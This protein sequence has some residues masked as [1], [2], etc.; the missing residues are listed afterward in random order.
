MVVS[1]IEYQL[2]SVDADWC[3]ERWEQLPDDGNRYEVIDG[4]LYMSTAPSNNHQYIT[5]RLTAHIG[6]PLE[7]AGVA[8]FAHAP[9]GVIMPG[10]D[11]VQPDFVLIRMERA[12]IYTNDIH[13]RDVPDVIAEILSPGNPAHDL[14]T[15]RGAYARAGVPEY[16]ILRPEARD[17]IVLS[18]PDAAA[19]DFASERTFSDGEDLVSPTLPIRVPVAALFDLPARVGQPGP[20]A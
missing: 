1:T 15:K 6:L 13:I 10:C 12:H 14:E 9:I 16:W 18:S 2:R 19:S 17:V 8:M 5:S 7:T 3:Y 20:T 11:P 4:V